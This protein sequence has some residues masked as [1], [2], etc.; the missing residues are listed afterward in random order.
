[1]R[2]SLNISYIRVLCMRKILFFVISFFFLFISL[3]FLLSFYS[4][5]LNFCFV[6]F[7]TYHDPYAAYIIG[8]VWQVYKLLTL[9][10]FSFFFESNR[11]KH[12][13]KKKFV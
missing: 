4:F 5:L 7:Y 13:C 12:T 2:G 10:G 3:L 8:G 1:M 9:K 11:Q 6:L